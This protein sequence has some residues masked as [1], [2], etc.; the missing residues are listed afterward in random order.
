MKTYILKSTFLF[1]LIGITS[2]NTTKPS[3]NETATIEPKD[4]AIK[5]TAAQ[6][7]SSK[8][9]LGKISWQT[10]TE[11][12]KT[13]GFIDVP[14]ANRAKVSAIM[15]GYVKNSPLLIGDNVKKGQLLLTIENPDFIEIQQ[16]YLE[17]TEKLSYLKLEYERHKILF[18]EKISSQKN[19]LK[20]ESNYK[21]TLATSIGLEQKLGLLGINPSKVKEGNITSEIGIYAPISGSITDVFTSVGEFKTSSEALLEIINIDHKHLEL[22]VFEK[23]VLSVKKNQPIKFSMPDSSSKKY[24]A[25][26][27]LVGKSIDKNRTVKVHGHLEDENESFIVGM[28]VEA[29]IVT[30][31]HQKI[32]LPTSSIL[33]ED[34]TYFILALKDKNEGSYTFEKVNITIGFKN[35]EWAEVID[36]DKILENKQ[37]LLKGAFYL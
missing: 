13:N 1:L 23:D 11:G 27:Y 17:I 31:S 29:E 21:S 9:E 18:N 30:N 22:I 14:P 24:N 10:F 35:E 26:V 15:G 4:T 5:I 12:I 32:A 3:E 25:E 28:Y 6:F 33:E 34:D 19:Y 16:N 2:C 37:I 8:M 7:E 20:A 36:G